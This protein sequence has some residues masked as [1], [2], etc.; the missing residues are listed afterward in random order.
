M[1][2]KQNF[3]LRLWN[4]GNNTRLVL[5]LI[6]LENS[7]SNLFDKSSAEIIFLN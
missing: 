2:V 6:E 4:I 3:H 7:D 1:E 5:N